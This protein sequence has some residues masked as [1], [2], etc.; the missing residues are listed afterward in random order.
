M[1][2]AGQF[3]RKTKQFLFGFFGLKIILDD[4]SNEWNFY[5]SL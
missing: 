1:E 5:I 3:N 4:D 2:C